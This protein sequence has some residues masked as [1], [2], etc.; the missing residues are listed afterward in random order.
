MKF[1]AVSLSYNE[2]IVL[3]N[4]SLEIH[5]KEFIFLIGSS[6][7]G[8]TSLIRAML[9]AIKPKVGKIFTDSNRDISTFSVSELL[10]YRRNI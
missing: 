10:A 1:D 6:G 9:G 4:L 8:K 2:K 3:R 5:P 7:S